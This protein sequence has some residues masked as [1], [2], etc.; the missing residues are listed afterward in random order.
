MSTH[1]E[2]EYQ[3]N[4][5]ADSYCYPNTRI[6]INKFDIR[7]YDDL[8]ITERE[9]TALKIL[10]AEKNPING[11][12]DLKHLKKIHKFIFCDIYEWAGQIRGGDFLIK[13][14]S[15][16]CRS[17]FIEGMAADIQS[18]L[19]NEKYLANLDKSAFISRIAYYMGE[20]NALHPFR[21]G[22]GRTQRLYFRYLCQK[23]GYYLEFHS[24]AKETLI[25][26]DIMAF[27]R[28]YSLLIEV[29]DKVVSKEGSNENG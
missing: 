15:I 6:L 19:K 4:E 10:E 25:K 3:Y 1:N 13:D 12:F 8:N 11:R 7:N 28:D 5:Q 26:A 18:K 23:C 9:I 21:E 20:I 29:L 16:F 22:N 14:E 24:I 2:Y 27:N 17:M